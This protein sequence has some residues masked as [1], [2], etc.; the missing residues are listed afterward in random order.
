MMR[1]WIVVLLTAWLAPSAMGQTQAAL[2]DQWD[3]LLQKHVRAS[4]GVDYA[5]LAKDQ[6]ALTAFVEAHKA[7]DPKPWSDAAKKAAYI[8]LYNAGMALNLLKHAEAAKLEVGGTAF[9]ALKINDIKVPGGNI[10]NGDYK[11]PLAG[12][13]VTLDEIEHGLIRG[14]EAKG[15][16]E[17]LKVKSLDPR[18]HAAVNCAAVS[19]PR[20]REKAYREATIDQMLDENMREYLSTEA[21]FSKVDGDTMKANSIVYWYY[22]DFESFGKAAGKGGG[23]G[24]YLAQ[25]V[26]E[27]TKDRDWKVKHLQEHFNDRGRL[28]LKLSSAFDFAYDWRVNDVKNLP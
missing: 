4:G 23:A 20:V 15:Q 7:I 9:A 28:S 14:V 10:W 27:G 8:N 6:A 24:T 13:A 1:L 25:F 17:A 5:G 22:D 19:C 21:Q 2:A 16:L 18:I 12:L 26:T 3:A 11:L